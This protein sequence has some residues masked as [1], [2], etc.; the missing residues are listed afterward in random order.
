MKK[1]LTIED[2]VASFDNLA[3]YRCV[4]TIK[5]EFD[6][7]ASDFYEAPSKFK[8]FSSL[9]PEQ[10]NATYAS[11]FKN[12]RHYNFAGL[13][14]EDM[15]HILGH[16]YKDATFMAQFRQKIE[17]LGY[18][19][20]PHGTLVYGGKRYCYSAKYIPSK[21]KI[22]QIFGDEKKVEEVL[23]FYNYTSKE[24]AVLY[25]WSTKNKG[26]TN[27]KLPSDKT[28]CKKY[29]WTQETLDNLRANNQLESLVCRLEKEKGKKRKSREEALLE[30]IANLTAVVGQLQS[31]LAG[32]SI[33]Q[34]VQESPKTVKLLDKTPD[35]QETEK[36]PPVEEITDDHSQRPFKS[37]RDVLDC[38]KKLLRLGVGSYSTLESCVK[39][40]ITDFMFEEAIQFWNLQPYSFKQPFELQAWI[41]DVPPEER[42]RIYKSKWKF[43]TMLKRQLEGP[44]AAEIFK[45]E[46]VDGN[47]IPASQ[48]RIRKALEKVKE[49]LTSAELHYYRARDARDNKTEEQ[50][51]EEIKPTE[52]VK[53]AEP[54]KDVKK[55]EVEVD[56]ESCCNF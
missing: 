19:R 43:L 30:Q 42:M 44:Y 10:K 11:V 29:N 9:N 13:S 27:M 54:K 26:D 3:T 17:A 32:N 6:G 47:F 50:A 2:Y 7:K 38:Y 21:S 34:E 52:E 24:Q 1:K 4:R 56:L 22:F 12:I 15:K 14:K 39:P 31:K 25:R 36:E 49:A 45:D 28:L 46:M 40:I 20:H 23:D 5:R 16:N 8:E 41:Q 18:V 37:P 48:S 51:V 55:A 35:R 33:Q 53:Q